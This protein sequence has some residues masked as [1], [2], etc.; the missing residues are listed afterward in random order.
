MTWKRKILSHIYENGV[1][2]IRTSLE[3]QNLYKDPNI[4]SD[5]QTGRLEWLDHMVRMEDFR[6]PKKILNAKLD[7]KQEIGRSK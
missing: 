1:W 2:Q 7:K 3:P 6:L 4:I 5:I